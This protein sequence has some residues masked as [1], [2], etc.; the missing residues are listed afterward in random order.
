M[1]WEK[2]C[3]TGA[4]FSVQNGLLFKANKFQR[5]A[6]FPNKEQFLSGRS[7][8]RAR[9][10]SEAMPDLEEQSAEV[11]CERECPSNTGLDF[12]YTAKRCLCRMNKQFDVTDYSHFSIVHTFSV[13]RKHYYILQSRD[14]FL[15][16][17]TKTGFTLFDVFKLTLFWLFGPI[18]L[19]MRLVLS[20]RICRNY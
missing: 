11:Q 17:F 20:S 14:I 18:F 5:R 13:W 8:R 1:Y 9:K 4:F 7:D 15:C 10:L 19:W 6:N 3:S 16:I 2:R 12:H